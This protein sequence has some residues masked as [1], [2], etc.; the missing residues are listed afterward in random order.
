M[1]IN[2]DYC[3]SYIASLN[4]LNTRVTTKQEQIK[5]ALYAT[6]LQY[7]SVTLQCTNNVIDQGKARDGV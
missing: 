3:E 7:K 2:E 5:R 1:K 4:A 6:W